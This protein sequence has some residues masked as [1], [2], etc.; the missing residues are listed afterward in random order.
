V[1]NIYWVVN[2]IHRDLALLCGY[3]HDY[4]DTHSWRLTRNNGRIWVT[5]PRWID[6]DQTP[7]TNEYFKPSAPDRADGK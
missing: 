7:R 4:A 1:T 6:P 3:H 5:P 2:P